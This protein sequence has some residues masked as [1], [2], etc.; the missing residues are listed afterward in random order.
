M[1]RPRK[2]RVV[3]L[4]INRLSPDVLKAQIEKLSEEAQR[5]RDTADELDAQAAQLRDNLAALERGELPAGELRVKLLQLANIDGWIS[6]PRVS[7]FYPSVPVHQ[8]E[9]MVADL[10]REGALTRT[11][12][13]TDHTYGERGRPAQIYRLPVEG[14][15]PSVTIEPVPGTRPKRRSGQTP[16]TR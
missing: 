5:Y 9:R 1:A 3:S 2:P 4:Q 13:D 12:G 10:C 11:E 6:I 8:I 16:R 7:K 15:G 14:A